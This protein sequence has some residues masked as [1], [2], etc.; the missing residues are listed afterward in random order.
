MQIVVFR[1]GESNS[2]I[3]SKKIQT[4]IE[5][6]KEKVRKVIYSMVLGERYNVEEFQI[7]VIAQRFKKRRLE[8][9]A[10]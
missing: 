5:K 6:A 3:E 8:I 4:R 7:I 1:C 2:L 9:S 10:R